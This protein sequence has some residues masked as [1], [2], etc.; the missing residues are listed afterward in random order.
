MY[1]D[2]LDVLPAFLE[3]V[4]QSVDGHHAVTS[5]VFRLV[6]G[7]ADWPVEA[8]HLLE[9]DSDGALHLVELDLQVVSWLEW[10]WLSVD[11]GEGGSEDLDDVLDLGLGAEDDVVLLGPTLDWTWLVLVEGLCEGVEGVVLD[12]VLLATVAVGGV[13]QHQDAG[14]GLWH[15]W[16][17]E[18][19][20]ETW[21]F[22][23]VVVLE[24]Y[25]Q[26]DGLGELVLLGNAGLALFLDDLT[27]VVGLG[28]L[29]LSDE[30][31]A[32][33]LAL[34]IGLQVGDGIFNFLWVDVR[35]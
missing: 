28:L 26:F 2:D 21:V 16:E 10:E 11:L 15:E 18:W 23:G 22:L 35:H 1:V 17:D 9:L 3:V 19:L 14:V 6:G 32:A 29:G 27:G 8:E 20:V 33:V 5:D 31:V 7:H 13:G 24:A 25:L 34:G 12:V 30:E 4:D